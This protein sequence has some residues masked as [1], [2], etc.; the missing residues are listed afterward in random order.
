MRGPAP[1]AGPVGQTPSSSAPFPSATRVMPEPCHQPCHQ[2]QH[3]PPL[4]HPQP[5]TSCNCL[6]HSPVRERGFGKNRL[7]TVQREHLV[8]E[9]DGAVRAGQGG[10]SCVTAS[11]QEPG[12]LMSAGRRDDAAGRGN[13]HTLFENP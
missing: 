8:T 1:R 3:N 10:H 2:P 12:T 9:R 4:P 11:G 7:E 6:N 5:V 13:P